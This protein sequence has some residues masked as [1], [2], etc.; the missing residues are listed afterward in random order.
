MCQEQLKLMEDAQQALAHLS[1]L[2]NL[3]ARESGRLEALR[4]H[5]KDHGC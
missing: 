4:Q 5:Q 2:V 1:E 3:Q